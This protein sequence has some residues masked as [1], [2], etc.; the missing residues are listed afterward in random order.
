[1][2]LPGD[3]FEITFREERKT[4]TVGPNLSNAIHFHL[5]RRR[6]AWKDKIDS[7]ATLAQLFEATIKYQ[8]SAI[9]DEHLVRHALD[10]ADLVS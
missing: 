2:R 8:A 1:M 10:I 5:L 6:T 3:G 9:H 4:M 7:A